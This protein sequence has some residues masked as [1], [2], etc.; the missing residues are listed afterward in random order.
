[1]L[2]RGGMRGGRRRVWVA[3][4]GALLF[5]GAAA[6]VWRLSESDQGAG[7]SAKRIA[8]PLEAR[9]PVPAPAPAPS[10]DIG[11]LPAAEQLSRAFA[12]AFGRP[13]RVTRTV[14]GS[15]ITYT[16]GSLTWLGDRAVLLSPGTNADD[17]HACAGTLAVHYLRPAGDGFTVQGEWLTGGGYD[18][19]GAAPDGRISTELTAR[20]ALR[21]ENGGGNQGVFCTWLQYYA[22]GPE[23]PVEIANIAIGHSSSG[24]YGEG[25]GVE[26]SGRIRNVRPDRSFEVHYSGSRTFVE[27]WVMRDGVFRLVG[28]PTRVP[29][30]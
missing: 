22:L 16:P 28:G 4:I 27:R 9:L 21:T 2:D 30:C 3:L 29:E 24:F 15:R 12:T 13:G 20:P 25:R 18:D 17:C 1:M 19:F 7:K 23:G 11:R 14:E 5:A 6:A 10:T 8:P 26:L